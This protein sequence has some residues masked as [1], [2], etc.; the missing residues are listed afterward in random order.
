MLR[1]YYASL[2][3]RERQAMALVAP[4]PL[5]KQVGGELGISEIRAEAYR[6]QVTQKMK[7]NS[8]ADLVKIASKNSALH[9]QPKLMLD[10]FLYLTAL[11][12][13]CNQYLGIG[14]RTHWHL[15]IGERI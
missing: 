15:R 1:E 9:L 2:T 3:P 11:I 10:T 14:M 6:G 7:A 12:Q 5:N 4:G 13:W 8:V